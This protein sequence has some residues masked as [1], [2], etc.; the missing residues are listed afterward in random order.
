MKHRKRQESRRER[1]SDSDLWPLRF[2]KLSRCNFK[3]CPCSSLHALC[4]SPRQAAVAEKTQ[5][6]S[7]AQVLAFFDKDKA[8]AALAHMRQAAPHRANAY[9]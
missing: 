8:L 5:A 6:M 3:A 4:P 9:V 2:S 7:R 1:P